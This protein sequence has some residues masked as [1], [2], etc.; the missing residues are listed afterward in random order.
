M[1]ENEIFNKEQAE[2]KVFDKNLTNA[3]ANNNVEMTINK[4]KTMTKQERKMNIA[5]RKDFICRK[6][7]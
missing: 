1:K 4:N 2:E 5:N 3:L 6:D 7:H